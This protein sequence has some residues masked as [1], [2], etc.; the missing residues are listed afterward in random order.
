MF[1][2]QLYVSLFIHVINVGLLITFYWWE[3]D[4]TFPLNL[5]LILIKFVY[6][7]M[8]FINERKWSI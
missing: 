1:E 4:I 8:Y 3:S 5:N 2:W 6:F 7:L